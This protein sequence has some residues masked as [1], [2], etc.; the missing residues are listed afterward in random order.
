MFSCSSNFN[1]PL[2]PAFFYYFSFIF[3][4]QVFDYVLIC[5]FSL[6]LSCLQFAKNKLIIHTFS[7]IL[8]TFNNLLKYSFGLVLYLEHCCLRLGCLMSLHRS[9]TVLFSLCFSL[10]F[11]VVEFPFHNFRFPF[12]CWNFPSAHCP[13][14]LLES[15]R[16][17][18]MAL[19]TDSNICVICSL[20]LLCGF[21][22]GVWLY[23]SHFPCSSPIS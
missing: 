8:R 3:S 21:F 14:F 18:W 16:Y 10:G 9:D 20:S 5:C 12:L 1:V 23:M 7:Y 6:Y 22:W 2:P 13:S 19:P 11:L 4:F 17:Y 15:M